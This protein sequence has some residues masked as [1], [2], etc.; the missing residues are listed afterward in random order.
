MVRGAGSFE[1][2]VDAILADRFGASHFLSPVLSRDPTAFFTCGDL[3]VLQRLWARFARMPASSRLDDILLAQI[4]EHRAEVF[5]N[6]DP[7]RYSTDF[8]RR[9]PACVK[10]RV[11]WRAAPSG[12]A[13]LS[14]YDVLVCNFPSILEQYR[15]M[16]WKAEYFFPAHDPLMDEFSS[17]ESRP[18]DVLFAGTFSRHHKRR[19][20]MLECL[21]EL[22]GE[23]RVVFHL[24]S[25]RLTRLS[26]S[27]VGRLLP[28]GAYRRPKSV[29]SLA[30]APVFGLNLYAALSQ[31][32]IVVNGAID[33]A[34]D[35]RG[36]MRCFEA[37]GCGALLVTDVGRYPEGMVDGLTMRTYAN[38]EEVAGLVRELLEAPSAIARIARA[39][40]QMM[41]VRYSKARQWSEFCRLVENG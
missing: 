33:M 37:M 19:A 9:L 26:E 31:A 12:S 24:D 39:G 32:K 16:G 1:S 27:A 22:D 6:L 11:A 15:R 8:L 14:G 28:L 13:D 34:G 29:R 23:V 38:P 10:Y 2:A 3:Q 18:I 4:E 20:E 41:S 25:S 40:H 5:Y 30:S 7:L 17:N 35:D 21:A 36:N